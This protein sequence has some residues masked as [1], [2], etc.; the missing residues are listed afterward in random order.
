MFN[1]NVELLMKNLRRYFAKQ[2]Y[3]LH[4]LKRL[5]FTFREIQIKAALF[6]SL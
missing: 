5:S 1:F 6:I 3:F 2:I 4:L